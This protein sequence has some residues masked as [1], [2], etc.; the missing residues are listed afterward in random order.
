MN[1]KPVCVCCTVTK[2]TKK[3][4]LFDEFLYSFNTYIYIVLHKT[5]IK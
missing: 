4:G 2:K 1:K 5:H 3:H